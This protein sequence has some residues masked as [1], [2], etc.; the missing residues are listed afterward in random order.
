VPWPLLRI[1]G[2]VVPMWRELAEMR[3]LWQRPHAL[4]GSALRAF[5]GSIQNTPLRDALVASLRALSGSPS[6][7]SQPRSVAA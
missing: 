3:Y 5:A 7:G 6:A 1:G 2:L 4:D